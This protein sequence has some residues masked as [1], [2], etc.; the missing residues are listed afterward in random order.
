LSAGAVAAFLLVA[1]LSAYVQTLTGFAFGLLVMGAVGLTGILPL[2]EAAVVVS[3][4]TLVNAGQM[5]AKGWSDI[6]RRELLVIIAAS[7]PMTIVGY[8][9]LAHLATGGI[10][11]LRILLGVVIL[12]SALQLLKPPAKD[13]R[14]SGVPAT[15]FFGA[16]SGLMGG[17]FSTSGPPLVYHLYRQPLPMAAIRETLV[18]VFALNALLRLG[19]VAAA[20]DFPTVAYWPAFLAIPAVICGTTLARRLPPPLSPTA[21]R[22]AVFVLLCLSGLSLALPSL[23]KLL[24]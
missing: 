24:A 5:V 9:V 21:I 20:G 3:V 4:L 10:D 16:L 6:R 19:M 8:A 17:L 23:A 12:V 7:L 11:G 14:P 22:L 18:A 15:L 13:K 2:P 1:G